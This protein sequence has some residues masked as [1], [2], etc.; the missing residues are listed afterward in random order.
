MACDCRGK[1]LT[2]EQATD[3]YVTNHADE[4]RRR[5]RPLTRRKGAYC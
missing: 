5:R 2:A 4:E 3:G 1:C